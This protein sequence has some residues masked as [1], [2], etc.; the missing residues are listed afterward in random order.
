MVAEHHLDCP[1]KPRDIEQREGRILRQGNNNPKV[2][3]FRYVTKN[4]F[5][6]YNW[7]LIENKQKFISQV[8]TSKSP[9]RSCEDVDES[10]LSYAEVKALATGDPRIK[11]KM[12]LDIQ[13]TKLKMLRSGFQSQHFRLEDRLLKYYPKAIQISKERIAGLEKD[14]EFLKSRPVPKGKNFTMVVNGIA[15]TS[16]KKAGTALINACGK[17]N[18]KKPQADIGE[19]RGFSL[20]LQFDPLNRKFH[21][22]LKHEASHSCELG[23]DAV[24]NIARLDNLLDSVPGQL[25][26]ARESLKTMNRQVEESKEELKKTFPQEQELAEK[27]ERLNRLTLELDGSH[28]HRPEKEESRKSIPASLSDRLEK[29]QENTDLAKE[30]STARQSGEK[31]F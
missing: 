3:I 17:L 14:L 13:V 27:S 4:T 29:A 1:W 5:D 28:P 21:A 19:Y 26:D 23:L 25:E 9:A 8:M 15:Y 10:V 31:E 20:K 30:N 7:Q 2:K 16:R 22:V 12:D 24:G 18:S 6:S 11:E